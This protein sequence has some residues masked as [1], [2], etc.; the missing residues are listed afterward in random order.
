MKLLIIEDEKKIALFLKSG[1]EQEGFIVDVAYDGK[2]GLFL[3]NTNEYDLM[4]LDIMLPKVTGKQIC[5]KVRFDGKDYPILALTVKSEI[6]FKVDLFEAGVDDYV[7]KPFSFQELVARAR[8]LLK[9]PQRQEKDVLKIDNLSVDIR[10]HIVK[11]GDKKIDL[12]QKEFALLEFL[13]RNVNEAIS[14]TVIIENLW[15]VE[16]NPF[17]NSIETHISNLRNKIE[18]GFEKKLIHT[19]PRLGY[20]ISV[21]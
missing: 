9:R 4:I 13:L 20:R 14:K 1:F 17:S 16:V 19:V 6:E 12:T 18:K 2:E 8:S 10:K 3:A 21:D 7:V 5:E 15:G 11:R